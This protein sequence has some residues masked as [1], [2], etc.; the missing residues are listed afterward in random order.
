MVPSPSLALAL[1][2]PH[3]RPTAQLF[4]PDALHLHVH[5]HPL[6]GGHSAGVAG[7]VMCPAYM[8]LEPRAP[9]SIMRSVL[10][11]PPPPL[12]TYLTSFFSRLAADVSHV[13]ISHGRIHYFHLQGPQSFYLC[14]S[15][16][17]VPAPFPLTIF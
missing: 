15:V 2:P 7:G 16:L 8:E 11:P 10:G 17:T 9:L 1:P 4:L 12:H 6:S 5:W 13:F 3:G 14:P